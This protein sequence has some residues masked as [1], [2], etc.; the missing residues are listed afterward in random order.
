MMSRLR[1]SSHHSLA[2]LIRSETAVARN[3]DNDP[4]LELLPNLER[5]AQGLDRVRAL[6]GHPLEISSGYRSRELNTAVGG[7]PGS[8]HTLG[9]AADFC[10]EA[11]GTPLAIALAIAA[12]DI[13]F[14]QCI[15]E[16][17][18]WVHLSFAPEERREVLTIYDT[19]VGYL[20]GLHSADGM[21]LA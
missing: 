11:F 7:A 21:R 20:E 6:L 9:L 4:P 1:L 12:S 16:F 3:I 10:C 2:E 17:G 19:E 13:P 14:D 8:K 18:R 15:L 5:L